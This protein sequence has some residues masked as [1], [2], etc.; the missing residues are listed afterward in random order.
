MPILLRSL[1]GLGEE[2]I[3]VFPSGRCKCRRTSTCAFRAALLDW[4][5]AVAKEG[6]KDKRNPAQFTAARSFGSRV[7]FANEAGHRALSVAGSGRGQVEAS[8]SQLF[9]TTSCPICVIAVQA[10][11][12]PNK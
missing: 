3:V 2:D 6:A 11:P 10:K 8:G 1:A 9:N 12:R 5:Q 7:L 4:P